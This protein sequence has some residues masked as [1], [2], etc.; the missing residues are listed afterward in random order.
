VHNLKNNS[1]LEK[2][3]TSSSTPPRTAEKEDKASSK[4]SKLFS[5]REYWLDKMGKYSWIPNLNQVLTG[6]GLVY[7]AVWLSKEYL[8]GWILGLAISLFISGVIYGWFISR[9]LDIHLTES[10]AAIF[11]YSGLWLQ[12]APMVISLFIIRFVLIYLDRNGLADTIPF[13]RTLTFFLAGVF[14]SR[15]I[16]ILGLIYKLMKQ[17][18]VKAT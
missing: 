7:L 16:T 13:M 18:P 14:L 11:S 17:N 4:G 8:E 2:I 9:R 10:G 3:Q 12:F 15:G 6:L 5:R 1:E